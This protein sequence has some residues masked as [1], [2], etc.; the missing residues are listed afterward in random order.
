MTNECYQASHM[1]HTTYRFHICSD[2]CMNILA[3]DMLLCLLSKIYLSNGPLALFHGVVV[4]HA[5]GQVTHEVQPVTSRW[6]CIRR[7]IQNNPAS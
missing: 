7:S 6:H 1:Q 3:G 2:S 4:G 5:E